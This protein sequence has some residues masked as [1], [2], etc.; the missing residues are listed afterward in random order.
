MVRNF[1]QAK[2]QLPKLKNLPTTITKIQ[3]EA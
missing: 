3:K 1:L 2:A